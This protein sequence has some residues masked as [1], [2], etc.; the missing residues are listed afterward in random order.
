MRVQFTTLA[1]AF[2]VF[3]GPA[4]ASPLSD[5]ADAGD[6]GKVTQLVASGANV[7]EADIV[8][9]T[10]LIAAL[11]GCHLA[12]VK[13]LLE[14]GANPNTTVIGVDAL[15][16]AINA[17]AATGD[18]TYVTLMLDHGAKPDAKGEEGYTDLDFAAGE[19]LRDV[20][21][22]LLQHGADPAG[23]DSKGKTAADY[24]HDTYEKGLRAKATEDLLR[25]K[26]R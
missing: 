20:V 14:H 7:N 5:A 16:Q 1:V 3:S 10:P 6:L 2:L 4:L 22:V 11:N 17:T 23:R 12:V 19:G 8:G 25:A 13:F 15:S 24:A 21:R 9:S 26:G 18:M